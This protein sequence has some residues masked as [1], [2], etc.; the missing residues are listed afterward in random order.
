MTR[1]SEVIRM[2][3]GFTE[4]AS[5]ESAELVRRSISSS[6]IEIEN[7][8]S[9]RGGIALEDSAYYLL[10]TQLRIKKEIVAVN[11]ERLFQHNDSTQDV[12]LKGDDYVNVPSSKRT[13]Y[14][15]GQVVTNGHIPFVDGE[16][17]EY[18]LR[19]AGGLTDRARDGDIRIVKAKTR[20]WLAPDD[21]TIEPGDYVWVPRVIEHPF[22]YTM[23]LIGQT[24]SV[25]SVAVSIVLL[26][27]QINK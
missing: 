2:A 4:S 5:L 12:I 20:Q 26:V 15:Y 22:G 21:T 11:F 18:Y 27:I 3:G 24:A 10:E 14:V 8:E 23:N 19:K 16:G 6:D 25:L 7:L 9:A 13:V 1:L 17:V